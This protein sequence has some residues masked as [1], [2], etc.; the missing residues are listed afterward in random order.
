LKRLAREA[1]HEM[2]TIEQEDGTVKRF[3]RDAF[4]DCFLHETE[5]GRRHYFGEDPGPA[6]PM[7]EALRDVS[8]SELARLMRD[9]GTMFG[10]FV[11]EDEI[12]RGERERPG[13]PTRETSP[14]VYE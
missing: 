7:V 2:I 6:H 13:P 10:H 9:H 11:G 12:I 14:G 8:D 3:H 5:R 4:M 1:E